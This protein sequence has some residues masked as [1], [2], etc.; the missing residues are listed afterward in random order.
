MQSPALTL[1]VQHVA[2]AAEEQQEKQRQTPTAAAAR[3]ASHHLAVP[4]CGSVLQLRESL[5]ATHSGFHGVVRGDPLCPR[6]P[7][8]C[9]YNSLGMWKEVRCEV[10]ADPAPAALPV[11]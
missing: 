11:E 9:C 1:A 4:S 3:A 6:P 5:G 8:L 7:V 2:A 10:K